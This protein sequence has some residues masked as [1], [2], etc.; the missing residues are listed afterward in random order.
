[1]ISDVYTLI[2]LFATTKGSRHDH[3]GEGGLSLETIQKWKEQTEGAYREG[4]FNRR[5]ASTHKPPPT[6]W[7][8]Q[9]PPAQGSMFEDQKRHK[10]RAI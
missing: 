4:H 9:W 2:S 6:D 5:Q 1:M 3:S 8:P 7:Q 10:D